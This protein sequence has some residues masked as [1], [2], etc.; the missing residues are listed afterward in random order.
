MNRHVAHGAGL[1]LLRL[2]V[3]R[4]FAWREGIDRQGVTLKTKH[5]HL[6]ALQQARIRGPMRRM[7][8]DAAFGLHWSVFEDERPGFVGVTA[9]A[10]LVLSCRGAQLSREEAAVWIMAVAAR[11]Q[12]FIHA[13]VH[14]LG[15]LWAY[16][17]VAPIAKHRLRH[18]QQ[19]AFHF[20]MMS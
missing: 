11:Q 6:A 14:R 19:R 8:R 15:K 3:E 10:N 18:L 17:L 9:E 1:I 13:V 7:A 2:V 12:A 5:I 4:R 16:L 20:G